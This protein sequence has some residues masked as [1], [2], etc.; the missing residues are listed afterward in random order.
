MT[1]FSPMSDVKS[2]F[3]AHMQEYVRSDMM[4]MGH[5]LP[6][7]DCGFTGHKRIPLYHCSVLYCIYQSGNRINT[8]YTV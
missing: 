4:E 6:S 2:Y 5:I 3:S 8:Q 7:A 1:L